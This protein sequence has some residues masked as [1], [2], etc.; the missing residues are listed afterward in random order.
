[1]IGIDQETGRTVYH[2]D[3]LACRIKRVLTTQ[4]TERVKRRKFGNRALHRLGKNQSPHEA[5]IVQN[6][7][8]EALTNCHCQLDGLSVTRCKA[9][10]TNTG[11]QVQIWAKW[12][13][14]QIEVS[15]NV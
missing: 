14:E 3:A 6:L 4:L 1:M 10:V 12:K 7:S 13:G 5:L 9:I 2:F 11:F 15:T 8:I